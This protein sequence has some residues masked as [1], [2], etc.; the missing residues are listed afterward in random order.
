MNKEEIA[1]SYPDAI[2]VVTDAQMAEAVPAETIEQFES[3][4]VVSGDVVQQDVSAEKGLMSE[5]V[6]PE[7]VVSQAA[8]SDVS[9][10]IPTDFL[11]VQF[12]QD[13][14]S[15]TARSEKDIKAFAQELKHRPN[16]RLEI[17]GYSDNSGDRGQNI[18]ISEKRAKSVKALFERY[19]VAS[20]K[21]TAIGKGDLNP[22]ASNETAEGRAEN[23]RVEVE[24]K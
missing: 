5:A 23:R 13:S 17:I 15:V 2:P 3:K 12:E 1:K 9:T 19:G 21:M 11:N 24:L 10:S 18:I 16:A 8:E 22:I 6:A 20:S 7:N 14:T 4:E